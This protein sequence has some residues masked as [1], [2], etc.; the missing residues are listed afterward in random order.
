VGVR[1]VELVRLVGLMMIIRLGRER[2]LGGA[3]PVVDSPRAGYRALTGFAVI[4]PG[5]PELP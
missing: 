4:P 3:G 1:A 2:G 5:G